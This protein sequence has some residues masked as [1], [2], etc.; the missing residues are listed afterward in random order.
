MGGFFHRN[1][2]L[3]YVEFRAGGETVGTAT[4]ANVEVVTE[5]LLAERLKQK[6][7]AATGT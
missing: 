6:D 3:V 2:Q 4:L 5:A 1:T 7:D